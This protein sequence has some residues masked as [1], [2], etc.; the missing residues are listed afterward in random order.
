MISEIV[1][2]FNCITCYLRALFL[3]LKCNVGNIW[4]SHFGFNI[5]Q[6]SM[7]DWNKCFLWVS[8]FCR[9]TKP[10]IHLMLFLYLTWSAAICCMGNGEA[11]TT[12]PSA[13]SWGVPGAALGTQP[14]LWLGGELRA[15]CPVLSFLLRWG[16]LPRGCAMACRAAAVPDVWLGSW[17]PRQYLPFGSL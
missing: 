9:Q 8:C 3:I 17:R 2:G 11:N 10:F 14:I 12:E 15:A 6:N 16:A 7:D 4:L 5:F 13:T 1:G